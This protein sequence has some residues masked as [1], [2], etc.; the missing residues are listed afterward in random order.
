MKVLTISE[1]DRR[2]RLITLDNGDRYPLSVRDVRLF[3]LREEADIDDDTLDQIRKQVRSDCMQR[4]GSLLSGRDYTEARL[5]EKL[6]DDDYPADIID[7]AVEEL[8]EAG[9]LNEERYAAYYLQVHAGDRSRARIRRDLRERGVPADV[10]ERVMGQEDAE[11]ALAQEAAQIR[12]LLDRKDWQRA[13]SFREEM[14]LRDRLFRKGYS[15]E[16]VRMAMQDRDLPE[17]DV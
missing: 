5:R 10:I 1:T 8:R 15:S 6:E 17:E 2:R 12:H 11:E 14:K 9:Y 4:C 7:R 16:A 3:S 13:G